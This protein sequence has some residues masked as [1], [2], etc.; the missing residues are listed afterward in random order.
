ML[1]SGIACKSAS[2]WVK[3]GLAG[4]LAQMLDMQSEPDSCLPLIEQEERRRT[5]WSIYLLDKLVTCGR[6]RPAI[7][8]DYTCQL[9][10]PYS[11]DALRMGITGNTRTLEQLTNSEDL[12]GMSEVGDFARVVI[13]ASTLS[14]TANY[15]LQHYDLTGPKPPWDPNSEFSAL[16]SRLVCLE[17]Q[18]DYWRPIE[19]IIALKSS[20]DGTIDYNSA[21]PL[22]FSYALYHL[23]HC[24]LQHPFLLRRRLEGADARF[25]A[26][27]FSKAVAEG[28]A[29]AQALSLTLKHAKE[30]G[31]LANSSFLGYCTMVAGSIHSL[32]QYSDDNIIRQESTESMKRDMIFLDNHS[33]RWPNSRTMV[34]HR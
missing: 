25:P 27:F 20:I 9:H 8:Q 2:A 23:C 26:R 28:Q 33:L 34:S 24:L 32:F 15:I 31:C 19:E 30:G 7:L 5:Y 10:L 11:E 21:E 14:R 17:T 12:A 13:M 16:R 29:H 18:F 3:I 22:L 6:G 4:R 1:T